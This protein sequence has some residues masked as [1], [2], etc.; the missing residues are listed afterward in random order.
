MNAGL[1][2]SESCVVSE[3]SPRAD[4]DHHA[5]HLSAVFAAISA[6]ISESACDDLERLRLSTPGQSA[7]VPVRPCADGFRVGEGGRLSEIRRP[8]S[9]FAL[10]S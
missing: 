3:L 6:A 7:N 8:A 2:A 4:N 5:P 1:C 9:D 10:P